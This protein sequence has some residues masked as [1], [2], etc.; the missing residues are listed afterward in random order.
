MSLKQKFLREVYRNIQIFASTVLQKSCF[1]ASGNDAVQMFFLAPNR[2][3]FVGKFVKWEIPLV[4]F[5]ENIIFNSKRVEIRKMSEF[6][7][8]ELYYKMS[9]LFR[10]FLLVL[11]FF[12]TNSGIK[13]MMM[14]TRTCGNF[15]FKKRITNMRLWIIYILVQILFFRE[16]CSTF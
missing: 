14:S 8:A 5:W 15:V 11:K 10:W 1:W 9:D 7:C 2:N 13:K 16:G 6:F 3:M 12:A 4:V